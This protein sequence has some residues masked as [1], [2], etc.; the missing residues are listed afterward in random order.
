V[1][2]FVKVTRDVTERRRME[3][4]LRASETRYRR[5]FESARDGILI[6]D[7]GT[8]TITDV[9]P[10]MVELLG[11]TRDEFL[12][13]A[14][15]EIGVLRDA[16]ASQEAFRTLQATAIFGTRTYR[17]KPKRARA[18]TWS[19]SATSMQKTAIR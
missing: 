13:K 15:W 3:E 16:D 18:G 19:L 14:L 11:Y 5:L 8:H 12:G 9:N 2:G 4:R 10:F 17:F 7:A 6:V 1:R